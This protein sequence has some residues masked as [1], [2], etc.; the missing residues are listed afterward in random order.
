VPE[1]AGLLLAAGSSSRF[2]A[3][4]LLY[5]LED[6]LPLAVQAARVLVRALP[7]AIAVVRPDDEPLAQRLAAEGLRIV[8][9]PRPEE[10]M[11]TSLACGVRAT[12]DAA[13]WVIA[14]ADMPYIRT[15]TIVEVARGIAS[16]TAI[17]VPVHD[18]RR[19]HPVG[20]GRAY[21]EEL[22][23]LTGDAGGRQILARHRE[24]VVL[25]PVD[26]PGIL[27]DIDRVSDLTDFA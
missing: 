23:A 7:R 21:Y 24:R 19:G 12:A 8:L 22:S 26:D 3:P 16:P 6:G 25:V 10:G 15:E 11:G 5:P 17:V 2:G 20:F 9:N 4:K 14:L 18:G 1:R 27:R 13:G